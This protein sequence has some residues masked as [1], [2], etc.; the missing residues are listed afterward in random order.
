MG[1]LSQVAR[2]WRWDW[3]WPG[4][5]CGAAASKKRQ[6]QHPRKRGELGPGRLATYGDRI[7]ASH[8]MSNLDSG[9]TIGAS[10]RPIDLFFQHGPLIREAGRRGL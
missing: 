4:Q 7:Y 5:P 10:S 8:K 1:G 9:L 2:R 3:A 6:A